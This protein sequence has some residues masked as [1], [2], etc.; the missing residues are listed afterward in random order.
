MCV[1]SVCVCV[2]IYIYKCVCVCVCLCVCLVCLR[3][4]DSMYIYYSHIHFGTHIYTLF[5][6]VCV[7]IYS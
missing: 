4:Y 7:Y 5:T 3:V 6:Y 1:W 2:Y